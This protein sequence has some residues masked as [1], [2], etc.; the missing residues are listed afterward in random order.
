[1]KELQHLKVFS[2]IAEVRQY[3]E[4]EKNTGA[5]IGLVPTMGNLHEGHLSI[6]ERAKK[7]CSHAICTVYVNPLQFG[8]NEDLESYPRTFAEDIE[9]LKR[10]NCDAVFHPDTIEIYP[11]GINPHTKV[12]V[13]CLGEN[14]CGK[15]RPGHFD[16]VS[17]IVSKLL[18]I[19]RPE[20]AYFGLKD[21]QQF[22]IVSRMV[23]DLRIDC[24]IIGVETMRD[25]DGL[26][27]SSRNNYLTESERSIAPSLYQALLSTADDINSGNNRYR[28][29]EIKAEKNLTTN[30]LVPDY[31][32]ICNARNLNAATPQDNHLVILAAAFLGRTRL[33]DNLL[34][35]V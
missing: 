3:I 13:P 12:H 30:G 27:L 31:F 9:K 23:E 15:S 25:T 21:Y 14:Y 20:K 10:Y 28:D 17:T 11:D 7:E 34:L 29:L 5:R 24:E 33:I 4:T 8:P 26:A 1:L 22:L 2:H 32:S 6:V 35:D 16:G 19:C 18:N